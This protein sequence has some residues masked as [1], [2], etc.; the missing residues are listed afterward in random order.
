MKSNDVAFLEESFEGYGENGEGFREG[1]NGIGRGISE[2]IHTE[3][4]SDLGDL[5]TDKAYTDD[6]YGEVVQFFEGHFPVAEVR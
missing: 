3:S 4:V 2:Y 5:A 6:T 1:F